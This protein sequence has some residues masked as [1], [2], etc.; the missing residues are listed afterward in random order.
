M[1]LKINRRR[2]L[3]ILGGSVAGVG[4]GVPLYSYFIEPYWLA[5]ERQTL[6]FPPRHIPPSGLRIVHLSDLHRSEIVPDSYLRKCVSIANELN[7]DLTLLT[8]DYITGDRSWA[9]SLGE[10]LKLLHAKIGIYAS[11]GNHDGGDWAG[12]D[13][14]V[15]TREL[16]KAGIRVLVNESASLEHGCRPV[17]VVGLGDLWAGSFDPEAAFHD[18]SSSDFTIA[19]SHNPD[20]LSRLRDF[21]ANL[22]LCGHTHG[23]QVCIPLAG[24]PILPVEDKRFS[25]GVYR[26]GDQIA[27]VNRGVGL[28]RR[29][30]FN[31]RPE[32][33]CIDIA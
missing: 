24:P 7:P 9:A 26:I 23:G 3:R 19:L 20:T 12:F 15:V 16:Q 28:L 1:N 6:E 22:I 5:V 2:F 18:V 14:S 32:I 33:A 25:A 27:Y 31:C 8:G 13:T 4:V 11:L 10:L 30:R 29:V 21:S 17:A